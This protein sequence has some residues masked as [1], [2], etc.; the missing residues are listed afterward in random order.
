MFSLRT[1]RK[2]ASGSRTSTRRVSPCRSSIVGIGRRANFFAFNTLCRGDSP[3][4]RISIDLSRKDKASMSGRA[5]SLLVVLFTKRSGFSITYFHFLNG[6]MTRSELS[7][8]KGESKGLSSHLSLSL[9]S[10]S[11]THVHRN[12]LS[13][14]KPRSR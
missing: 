11:H 4:D 12:T 3:E 5:S 1:R 6:R 2:E 13:K 7:E 9:F 8:S 14:S 10:L